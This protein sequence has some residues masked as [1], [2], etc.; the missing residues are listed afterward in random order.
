MRIQISKEELQKKK[1]FVATPMYGGQCTGMYMKSCLDLQGLMS[2][3]G[4]ETKFSFI[5]N[6]SLIQRAR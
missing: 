4:V 2:K 6:E 1:L 3:Y 5:F